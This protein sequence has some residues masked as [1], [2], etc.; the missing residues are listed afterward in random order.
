M[1]TTQK[2]NEW[3]FSGSEAAKEAAAATLGAYSSALY[4]LCDDSN[5]KP[6]FPPSNKIVETSHSAERAVVKVVLTGT[7]N[8]YAPSVGLPIAR[9]AVAEY[10]N[11]DLP[12]KL[13][14]GDVYMTVGCKRAI[15]LAVDIL[16]KPKANVLLP[17]PGFPWDIVRSIYK[18]L[19]VRYYDF[20]PEKNFEIDF[21]SVKKVTDKNTFAIF[22]INPHNP[23]GNTYSE[24]HLKQLAELAKELSIMVVSD[25]V[26]RWT[27]FGNNPFVPMGKFSSIVPVVT[28]GSLSKGWTVPG[29]RTGWVA[30]HDLDGVFKNT[31]I[32][33]AANDFMQIN[34]KPPTIIQAAMSD[35]LERTPN[36]FFVERGNYLKHKVEIGYSKVKHIPG[37]TCYMKPEACTFLWT[38]LDISC[39]ADIEDD[40]DFCRKL[41]VEENLVVLPGAKMFKSLCIIY[42]TSFSCFNNTTCVLNWLGIAFSQK[43]WLRHS[44]DMDTQ[45]L[46]EAFERLKSFCERYFTESGAPRKNVNGVN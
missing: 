23:N 30:L 15:D 24:A 4:A 21:E 11:R 3:Q 43:N 5:G 28:L 37:L 31:K 18:N 13:T 1:A 17:R 9:S 8:A 38:K 39:F 40:E 33:Q 27:V 19:E 20:I 32:V 12:K 41:A 14:P 36:Y 44:I 34:A 29:W 42:N 46:E 2:C 10:L 7:G 16:A 26:F 22:I 35:I 25:E 6:I 45:T